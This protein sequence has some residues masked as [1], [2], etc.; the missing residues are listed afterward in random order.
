MKKLKMAKVLGLALILSIV[1]MPYNSIMALADNDDVTIIVNTDEPT[2]QD[3]VI[4]V[5]TSDDLSGIKEIVLPDGTKVEKES[6][7]FIVSENG[8][9]QFKV[10]DN[11]LNETVGYVEIKN[12][13]KQKPILEL[14]PSTINP[15]NQDVTITIKATDEGSGIKEI[16]LPDE[17]KIEEESA[18]FIV[19]ENGSY[20][21]IARDNAGNETEE[22]I[23][24]TN[25]DKVPPVI[26]V[27]DY[28]KEWTNKDIT[29]KV[30]TD[31]GTLNETE[32]IFTENGSF[33]FIATDEAGNITEEIVEI[34]N[35]D[36]VRPILKIIVGE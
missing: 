13:D 33:T 14:V 31:K 9:Y 4:T 21:F 8:N 19:S 20:T 6:T 18:E 35:I 7:E 15:T 27:D 32:Y 34:T 10:Y 2:N 29:V 16:I 23:E 24:I 22:V 5:E 30:S 26:T 12:I 28:T 17:T 3:I 11:A 25:I 1:V 36:K